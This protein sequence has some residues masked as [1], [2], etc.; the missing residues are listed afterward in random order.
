MCADKPAF[1][2]AFPWPSAATAQLRKY[3]IKSM[4]QITVA[5]GILL[6]HP[7]ELEMKIR[8]LAE[9]HY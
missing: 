2:E 1:L 5:N 9:A 8:S 3:T 7:A 4:P 6:K